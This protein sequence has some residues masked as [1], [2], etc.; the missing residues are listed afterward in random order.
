MMMQN[1]K[2]YKVKKAVRIFFSCILLF[3]VS[4]LLYINYKLYYQPSFTNIAQHNIN[5]DLLNE[6]QFLKQSLHNDAADK[7]Q[8]YYPEGFL[9]SNAVYA[10]S[11]IEVASAIN[12]TSLLYNEAHQEINWAIDVINSDK[13]KAR[14]DTSLQLPYGAFYTGW[15]NYVLGKKLS[16]ERESFRDSAEINEFKL[17]CDQINNVISKTIYPE[18]YKDYSWPADVFVCVAALSL[19]DKLFPPKYQSSIREWLGKVKMNLDSNGFIPYSSDKNGKP[20][21]MARG[22]AESLML[23][24][25][26]EIDP[27][28]GRKQFN[29]YEAKFL[30]YR[31]GLA[32][33]REFPK[34]TENTGDVDSGPVIFQMG[35]AAT[36]VGLRVMALYNDSTSAI[37]IRNG[38]EAFGFPFTGE[39]GK[40]YLLGKWPMADIFIAWSHTLEIN[41]DHKLSTS[42]NWRTAFQLYSLLCL[43]IFI[44]LLTVIWK[45][46]L[47]Q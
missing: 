25:L 19:H 1:L 36:I 5:E 2:I 39:D 45:R 40:K 30:D 21:E 29:L 4:I 17:K 3:L 34:G 20:I 9:F 44:L 27:G 23:N 38:L 41:K 10:L 22:S 12:D 32:G 46:R 31:L 37:A 7:M 33:I 42:E 15:S 14:F 47:A 16:I 28:F 11:W 6:L 13:G 26:F 18:S 35:S 8:L 24:F 43:T